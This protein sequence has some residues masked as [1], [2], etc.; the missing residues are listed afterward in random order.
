MTAKTNKF[1]PAENGKQDQNEFGDACKEDSRNIDGA[2][3]PCQPHGEV[4]LHLMTRSATRKILVTSCDRE[5][6]PIEMEP[7]VA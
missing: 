1:R 7:S 3:R 2:G 5:G 4:H 6:S